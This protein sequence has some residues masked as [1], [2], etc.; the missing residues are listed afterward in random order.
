MKHL[1]NSAHAALSLCLAA[2]LPACTSTAVTNGDSS[3]KMVNFGSHTKAKRISVGA[4]AGAI[5]IEGWDDNAADS[6]KSAVAAAKS[7]WSAYLTANGL[8][9]VMGKYYNQQ[10]K[11]TDA[12]TTVELE[13]LRNAK[14]ATE[15]ENALK[16][17]ELEHAAVQ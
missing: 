11:V 13:K 2:I 14:S 17:L 9:Y 3:V 4:L 1:L 15:G 12:G 10:G 7:A 8:K 6:L 5:V 16:A